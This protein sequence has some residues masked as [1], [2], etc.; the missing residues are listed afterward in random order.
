MFSINENAIWSIIIYLIVVLIEKQD[1]D[2]YI[3]CGLPPHV[4]WSKEDFSF[5]F[6][7]KQP[8]FLI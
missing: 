5:P 8:C 4:D 3:E 7:V 6:F 1:E 2:F